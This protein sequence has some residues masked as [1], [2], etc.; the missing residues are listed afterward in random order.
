MRNKIYS[1]YIDEATERSDTG[2]LIAY[3]RYVEDTTIN[4]DML[5]SKPTKRKATAKELF[6]IVD[7]ILQRFQSK[8]LRSILNAP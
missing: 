5:F 3:L 7:E 1:I 2:H 8:I 4:E 6:K